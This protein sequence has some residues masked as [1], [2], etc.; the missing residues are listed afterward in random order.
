MSGSPTVSSSFE[1][2][3]VGNR[4]LMTDGSGS[5]S[6][7]YDL[8]S[9]LTS[10]TRQFTGSGAPSGNFTLAYEYTL[11]G[12]IKKVTDQRALTS[13]STNFD[14]AGRLSTGRLISRK[15]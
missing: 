13:F 2:D 12:A 10:E 7:Q 11:A 4:T 5:T 15:T 6:Y 1:Y 3:A 9:R 14:A 8:L